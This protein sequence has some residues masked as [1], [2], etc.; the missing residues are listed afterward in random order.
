MSKFKECPNCNCIRYIIQ[1]LSLLDDENI[2]YTLKCRKCS[3][4]WGITQNLFSPINKY[5]Y[6]WLEGKLIQ[7]HRWVWEQRYNCK[8]SRYDCI[9]HINRNKGDDRVYNLMLMDRYTHNGDFHRITLICNRCNH[10]WLPKAFEVR[11]CPKCKSPYWD[12]EKKR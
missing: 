11:T 7:L 5:Q 8:L 1:K 12:A 4:I 3:A 10:E 6:I 2:K 9:H